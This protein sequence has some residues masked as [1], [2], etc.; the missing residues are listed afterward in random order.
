MLLVYLIFNSS[1]F[2]NF[3]IQKVDSYL[4]TAFK[5]EINIGRIN[6]D[7]WTTFSLDKI[8]WGD[9]KKDTLFYVNKLQFDLGG[10]ELD[11]SKFILTK[12]DIDG[13]YCKIVTYPDKTF[14]IDVLFNILDKN[15]TTPPD[16]NAQK[17]KL[18]FD[19]VNGTNCRF[20]F[21]DHTAKWDE[22]TGFNPFDQD[23]YGINIQSSHFKIIEDSLHFILNELTGFEKCGLQIKKMACK[24]IISSTIMEFENLNLQL[25]RS[26]IKDYGS[27]RYANYDSMANNFI[28]NVKL[29]ANLKNSYIHVSDIA[30]F[31]P[32][33]N[34]YDYDAT[35]TA[36]IN[37]TI[38]NISMKDAQLRYA[39]QTQFNGSASMNGLPNIDQT[40]I[41]VKADYAT[42]T[43]KEL[44]KLAGMELPKELE[45]F[46]LIKF[47]GH[48]TGFISDFVSYGSIETPF[49]QINTDLNMKLT[50]DVKQSIY[51]GKLDLRDFNLGALLKNNTQFGNITLT[52]ELKG[53]G[54]DF[55][56]L[57]AEA[58]T[59][60]DNFTFNGYNYK[61]IVLKGELNKKYFQGDLTI[62]DKNVKL[63]LAGK[64]DLNK[65]I[66]E[67]LFTTKIE[68]A[69]LKTLHFN[70]KDII[71]NT[72]IDGDF[73]IKT[74]DKNNGTLTIKN[75][76]LSYNDVDYVINQINIASRNAGTYDRKLI[77]QSD[78]ANASISG[79]Y[80]FLNLHKCFINILSKVIPAYLKPYPESEISKQ[81]F[82]FTVKLKNTQ[83]LSPL[84]FPD[85]DIENLEFKGSFN[86]TSNNLEVLGFVENFR[87]TNYYLHDLTLKTAITS[88]NDLN[89]IFG[90]SKLNKND[91]LLI[92]EFAFNINANN[93]KANVEMQIQDT[94]SIIYANINSNIQFSQH[95][96]QLQFNKSAINYNK[97]NWVINEDG[98]I[99]YNDSIIKLEKI[100]ISNNQQLL[101]LN[102]RYNTLTNQQ[103]ILLS[104]TDF[105]LNNINDVFPDL[106][107]DIHGLSNGN[108]IYQSIGDKN[109]F[110]GNLLIN[111]FQLD[112]DTIGDIELTSSFDTRNNRLGFEMNALNGKLNNFKTT[113]YWQVNN[114]KIDATVSL[115]DAD[116]SAF[117]PFAKD[118]ITLYEGKASMKALI[119]G[120][121]NKPDIDGFLELNKVKTKINYLQTTYSFTNTIHF[122]KTL[123][124]ILP[125]NMYDVNN[126]MAKVSGSI[127]H[128]NFKRFDFDISIKDFKDLLVLNTTSKDNSLYHGKAYGSG[129]MTIKGPLNDIAL[130]I[131]ATTEKNTKVAITPFGVGDGDDETLIH[132]TSRDTTKFFNITRQ[133]ELA[134]F[135]IDFKLHA[136]PQAEIQIIFDEQTDD[137]IR[138][139]GSG[140][141]KLELT[142]QGAFNMYGEYNVIE[143][144]YVFTALN[145]V[146]KKFFLKKSTIN[147]SGDPL[148]ASLNIFG[149][150]RQRTSI[151][152]LVS[153]SN[154][155]NQPNTQKT[156]VEAIMNIRGTLIQPEYKFDLNFPEIDNTM[157]SS[158]ISDLNLVV[159]NL[160][161]EPENMTQQIISLMV[162]G[163]F[164]PLNN[165]AN[166][167]NP[168]SNI[169]I[170]TLS[171]L[172][173]SQV[174]SIINKFVPNIDFNL[175][176]QNAIDPS[177]SRSVLLSA[178]TKFLNNRLEVM[179]SFATDNSQNNV[180]AQYNISTTGNFKA[181][182]F[183]RFTTDPIFNRG[184]I[185]TQ[186]IGLYY[187]KEFNTVRDLFRKQLYVN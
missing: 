179:G 183:N 53:K 184:N 137:K 115:T 103:N 14:N 79:K 88:N 78:F 70:D 147:W 162:F 145:I 161:K 114:N 130:T 156:L 71:V 18:I 15:D 33:L 54:L 166:T 122:D 146:P 129:F 46:G 119:S 125:F 43:K 140:E 95:N 173:S 100:L 148:N 97:S 80:D 30:F 45:R 186:G 131:D 117:Q 113:G 62:D 41:E 142:R 52:S 16:P 63:N 7:G 180:L 32:L 91:T 4:S 61:N 56:Y 169:G 167:L 160:R 65:D 101:Q 177:R 67:F 96:I 99:N 175:D 90:I 77:I 12:V 92:Q 50:D 49:G 68:N 178:S 74:I 112:N 81:Q 98:L 47:K 138:A 40:F 143:G 59:Q 171:E 139:T 128:N 26:T 149:V 38:D 159:S 127:N 37:G 106:Y 83:N 126:K 21:I 107:I 19:E 22:K 57:K 28:G 158:S 105:K 93:N 82:N 39:K 185:T 89:W 10:I 60:I 72:A 20:R 69:H 66:P 23:F 87:W 136:T 150:Y 111:A 118:Y 124:E 133:Q 55:K 25:N 85:Y 168:S 11:S 155:N 157:N 94:S 73:A 13:G 116:V 141:I 172:A 176:V 170:N 121:I 154:V 102:G 151:S 165:N 31:A 36:K 76:T 86:N 48:Y 17:F 6:Y 64:A 35:V 144:D 1:S 5:C 2:Q 44:D 27:M 163:R 174:T 24:T 109:V 132:F 8:Y 152:E 182:L 164:T 153:T 84:F 110:N 42:S 75:T 51:S 3:L 187:R 120:T 9:Q 123:I 108:I 34:Q 181:R 134:G 29:K 58:N 135:S 104:L